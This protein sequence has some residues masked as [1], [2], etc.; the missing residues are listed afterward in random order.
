MFI[1]AYTAEDRRRFLQDDSSKRQQ[2]RPSNTCHDRI[3]KTEWQTLPEAEFCGG[4]D[5]VA[6]WVQ[7]GWRAIGNGQVPAVAALAWEVLSK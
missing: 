7:Q 3:D 5:E 4:V 2:R 6:D 1:L